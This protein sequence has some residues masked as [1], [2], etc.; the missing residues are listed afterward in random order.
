MNNNH[1]ALRRLVSVLRDDIELYDLKVTPLPGNEQSL[2]TGPWRGLKDVH[3]RYDCV[4]FWSFPGVFVEARISRSPKDIAEDI[5]LLW[6]AIDPAN[7]DAEGC[8]Q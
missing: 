2:H 6:M 4:G 8:L 1:I 3:I 7:M 5:R